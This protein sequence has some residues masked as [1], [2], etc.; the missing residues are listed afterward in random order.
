MTASYD[1]DSALLSS[2]VGLLL[3]AG[4]VIVLLLSRRGSSQSLAAGE[5]RT[6]IFALAGR[7][8]V[9]LRDVLIL[10]SPE[11]RPPIAFAGRWGVVILNDG[12]LRDLS[13]REVD[14]IVCHELAHLR[15]GYRGSKM[16]VVGR[17]LRSPSSASCGCPWRNARFRL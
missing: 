7:A 1:S 12:V 14:A 6:R 15:A 8:G 5:L 9:T 10:T 17:S 11:S 13:R 3:T 4:L 2:T 16:I